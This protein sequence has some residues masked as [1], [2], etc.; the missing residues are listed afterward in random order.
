ML[1]HNHDE[2]IVL[3]KYFSRDNQMKKSEKLVPFRDSKLSRPF[4][5]A[6]SGAECL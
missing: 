2:L 5:R 3:F 1:P 4:Q 6:L